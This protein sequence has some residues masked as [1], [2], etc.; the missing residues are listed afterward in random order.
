MRAVFQDETNFCRHK[1]VVF[2]DEDGFAC[3]TQARAGEQLDLQLGDL[4]PICGFSGWLMVVHR[5]LNLAA[6]CPYI[7]LLDE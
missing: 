4:Y 1:T 7:I 6:L 3:H 2:E 5:M